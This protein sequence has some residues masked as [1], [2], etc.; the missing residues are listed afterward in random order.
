MLLLQISCVSIL[1]RNCSAGA[2]TAQDAF[3]GDDYGGTFLSLLL[4]PSWVG[5]Y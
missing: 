4:A 3:F 2:S 1:C 5:L